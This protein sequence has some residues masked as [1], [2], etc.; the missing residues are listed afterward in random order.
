MDILVETQISPK[1]LDKIDTKIPASADYITK[2]T[3]Q[4]KGAGQEWR[5]ELFEM[6]W[7]GKAT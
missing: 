7:S 6:E 4:G 5:E 1:N 3:K 2:K